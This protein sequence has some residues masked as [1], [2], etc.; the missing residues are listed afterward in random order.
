MNRFMI[1]YTHSLNT[2]VDRREFTY[3][4]YVVTVLRMRG[5][6]ALFKTMIINDQAQLDLATLLVGFV[7]RVPTY[8]CFC[9]DVGGNLCFILLCR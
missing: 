5:G 2:N 1:L 8:F 9:V 7:E 4:N 3:P 6:G